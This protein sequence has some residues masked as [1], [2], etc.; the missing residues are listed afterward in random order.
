MDY[1]PSYTRL[2]EILSINRIMIENYPKQTSAYCWH[3]I[4]GIRQKHELVSY[5]LI[6]SIVFHARYAVGYIKHANVE[7]KS[8][9]AIMEDSEQLLYTSICRIFLLFDVLGACQRNLLSEFSVPRSYTSR[10][11]RIVK[12]RCV[13]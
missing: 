6:L 4:V 1:R 3:H 7:L 2:V 5:H 11:I 8:C 10:Q 13:F 9:V 12:G